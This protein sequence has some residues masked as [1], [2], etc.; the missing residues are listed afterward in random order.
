MEKLKILQKEIECQPHGLTHIT[1]LRSHYTAKKI[2]E[3][4]ESIKYL[5]KFYVDTIILNRKC[6]LNACQPHKFVFYEI[7]NAFPNKQRNKKFSY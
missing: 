6:T 2:Q 3:S 4:T 1:N 5:N 7:Y